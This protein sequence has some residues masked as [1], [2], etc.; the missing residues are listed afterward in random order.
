MEGVYCSV[1]ADV[2]HSEVE[3]SMAS[4]DTVSEIVSRKSLEKDESDRLIL[5]HSDD[6]LLPF[7]ERVGER[8]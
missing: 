8:V 1:C 4:S 5:S 3:V 7:P 2:S 6:E